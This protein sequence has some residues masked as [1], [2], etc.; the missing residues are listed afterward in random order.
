MWLVPHFTPVGL[1][2][3]YAATYM[4]FG[5]LFTLIHVGYHFP[6]SRTDQRL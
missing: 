1:A 3:Y 2:V 5:T 6:N 4:V